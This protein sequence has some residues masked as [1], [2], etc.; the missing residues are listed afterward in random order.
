MR[1]ARRRVGWWQRSK[2]LADIRMELAEN[3]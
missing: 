1:L 3:R 2:H